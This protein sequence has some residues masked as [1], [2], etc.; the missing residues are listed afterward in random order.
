MSAPY[1]KPITDAALA[2]QDAKVIALKRADLSFAEIAARLGISKAS[3]HRAFHRALQRI[4][5]PEVLAYRAEQLARIALE[6]E[7]A[8]DIMGGRHIVVSNGH[9]VSEIIGR[10]DEGDPIYGDPL[11]DPGPTLAAIDRLIKLDDQEAKLLGMY[12]ETRVNLSGGVRYEVVGIDA[13]DL[14]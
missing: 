7:E 12:A 3:A 9:I 4:V 6:R 1:S 13:S 2:E 8:M 5:E 11:T 14:S 10:N